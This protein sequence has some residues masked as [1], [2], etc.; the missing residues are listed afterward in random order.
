MK[1]M[2]TLIL[3]LMLALSFGAVAAAEEPI[4]LTI[5]C[6]RNAAVNVAAEENTAWQ[7]AAAAVGINLEFID[8]DNGSWSEK[9][10]ITLAGGDLPDIFTKSSISAVTVKDNM[11]AGLFVNLADYAEYLPNYMAVLDSDASLK[12]LATFSDGS[13]GGFAQQANYASRDSKLVPT[14]IAIVYTPWLE[15][16]GMDMPTTLDE[17]YDVLVAFKTQDPN[18]NGLADEIPLSPLYGQSSLRLLANWFG[19]P[20]D[21]ASNYCGYTDGKAWFLAD[22][23]AYKDYLTYFNKLW[24]EDL[25]DNE[26]FT[27][28]QQQVLAKGSDADNKIG[29]SVASGAGLIWNADRIADCVYLPL[30]TSDSTLPVWTRRPA[31]Y[32]FTGVITTQCENIEKACEFMDQFY[33]QEGAQLAWLGTEGVSYQWNDDG[34]FSYIIPDGEDTNSVRAK[35]T[36]QP[37]GGLAA[38]YPDMYL[39]INDVGE[40]WFMTNNGGFAATYESYFCERYPSVT[41]DSR[42][43]KEL[44]TIAADII[45]YVDQSM[46][47]FITGELS[48]ENDWDNY[49][50]T[51]KNMRLDDMLAIMQ[52]GLDA[53]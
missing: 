5:M 4:T 8:V 19:L 43:Q 3:A 34:T 33:S 10:N 27:Q 13:I 16:V 47:Q 36:L 45:S 46:A 41:Y 23:D 29:V 32:V 2:L 9:F 52:A 1:K 37:G 24:S 31:G 40:Q 25:L 53:R 38:A 14:N 21:S 48:I 20:F 6:S 51:L 22:T 35:H 28:T 30:L 18:G 12:D 26:V 17:F 50:Q 49:V 42:D 39:D 15:A 44:D 11:D 7:A